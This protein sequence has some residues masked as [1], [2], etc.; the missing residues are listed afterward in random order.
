M[1][2]NGKGWLAVAVSFLIGVA[3]C[4]VVYWYTH[5]AI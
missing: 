5:Y 1:T 3:I 2:D 4:A